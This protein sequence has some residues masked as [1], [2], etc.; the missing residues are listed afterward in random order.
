MIRYIPILALLPLAL[1]SG[2]P[3]SPAAPSLGVTA[4]GVTAPGATASASSAFHCQVPCGIYGDKMRIDM[5]MEDAST[6]EK[7]M[8]MIAEL[9]SAEEAS[10]NQLVRWIMTKDEHAQ[11]IQ[12]TVASY[13]LAQRIKAPAE[14]DEAAL[15]KYHEQ[16]SMMHGITVAAMKCKQTTDA[17]HVAKL[18]ELA[19]AFSKT[20]F[21]AE[22]LEHLRGHHDGEHR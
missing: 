9:E 5:L 21:S 12:E 13:W 8:K 16:L 2:V 10:A 15:A 4:P 3:T 6:I 17:A 14:G 1:G 7:G 22:D 19:M 18:R 20:Y 11:S